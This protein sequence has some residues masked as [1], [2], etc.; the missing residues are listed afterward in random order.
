[1]AS[2]LTQCTLIIWPLCIIP[3]K[4]TLESKS[5]SSF[6]FTFAKMRPTLSVTPNCSTEAI[7]QFVPVSQSF[8]YSKN[9]VQ[10][11]AS[12]GTLS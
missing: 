12:A 5:V 2:E 10:R 8:V 9:L 1:M 3:E 7:K 6:V 4:I 11:E